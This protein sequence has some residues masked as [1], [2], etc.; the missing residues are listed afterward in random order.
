MVWTISR[1]GN[2][3]ITDDL[4]DSNW[5]TSVSA[6]VA[7]KHNL[8]AKEFENTIILRPKSIDD[9]IKKELAET[10]WSKY[11]NLFSQGTTLP[12]NVKSE[13]M[14]HAKKWNGIDYSIWEQEELWKKFE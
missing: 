11:G 7:E 12:N 4:G 1:K 3:R 2:Y 9:S 14:V 13:V 6:D 10:F 5:I 8:H